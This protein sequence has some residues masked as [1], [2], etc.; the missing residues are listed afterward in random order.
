MLAVIVIQ[1]VQDSGY[2]SPPGGFFII[3]GAR[4]RL[5]GMGMP[6]NRQI[7]R[8]A[9][10][11]LLSSLVICVADENSWGWAFFMA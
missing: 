1:C 2:I 10:K 7:T 4:Y 5:S 3:G 8:Q 9:P 6:A 11:W